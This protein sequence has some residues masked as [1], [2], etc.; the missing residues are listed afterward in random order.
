MYTSYRVK[1]KGLW[2]RCPKPQI[3]DRELGQAIT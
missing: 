1:T 3:T 2:I